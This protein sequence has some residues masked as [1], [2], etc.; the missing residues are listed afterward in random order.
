MTRCTHDV[1]VCENRWRVD[2]RPCCGVCSHKPAGSDGRHLAKHCRWVDGVRLLATHLSSCSS[3]ECEG[4]KPCEKRHCAM[5]RC[6]RHLRHGE[7]EFCGKCVGNVRNDLTRIADLCQIAPI[8]VAEG[9][10]DSEVAVLAGPVPE[11]STYTARRAW[12]VGGGLCRCGERCPDLQPTPAGPLCE[13]WK[14]CAHDVCRRR[15][16]RT[17]CPDLLAWLDDS[18]NDQLHPLWILGAWDWLAA[19]A[20]DHTRTGKVTVASAVSYLD[21]NLTDLSRSDDFGFDGFARELTDCLAYVE[22]VLLVA[23]HVE[24]GAPC[25][26]CHRAGRKPKPLECHFDL[27]DLTGDSDIW[28]CPKCEETW[29]RAQY[30]KYVEREHLR[31]AEAL[32]ASQIHA[33]YR[34]AESTLRRWAN[35]YR[36]RGVFRPATVRKR[37]KDQQGRQL[38]DVADVLAARE[39][40]ER[41]P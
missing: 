11:H 33:E 19:L 29:S 14:D 40:K 37:G 21:A 9:R 28:V 36:D 2:G 39:L 32:T 31:R 5:P 35:G 25:P 8:A 17:A 4:C 10:I 16:G 20:L 23:R 18:G 15:T 24:K 38:Y 3:P 7:L 41:T 12:A 1:T 22:K 13:D 6:S 34:V 30:D 27:E 26:E